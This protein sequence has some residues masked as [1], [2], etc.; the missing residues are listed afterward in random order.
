VGK[1]VSKFAFQMQPAAL[2]G[3]RKASRPGTAKAKRPGSARARPGTAGGS[4]KKGAPHDPTKI[5]SLKDEV[6]K[7]DDS[8][9]DATKQFPTA[10]GKM[11][12]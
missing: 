12:K 6:A 2:H 5:G 11:R 9:K 7:L 3:G 10:R 4:K 8:A 1:P